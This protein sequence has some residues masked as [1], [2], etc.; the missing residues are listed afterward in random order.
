MTTPTGLLHP[1]DGY[2]VPATK[3]MAFVMQ[4]GSSAGQVSDWLSTGSTAMANAA[5]AGVGLVRLTGMTTAGSA[6]FVFQANLSSTGVT[7]PTSG[8]FNSSTSANILIS[9]NNPV[10]YQVPGNSTGFSLYAVS[11]GYISMEMWHK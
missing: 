1:T 10:M 6:S 4:G 11:S 2:P 3:V 9:G 8:D 7:A 5:A